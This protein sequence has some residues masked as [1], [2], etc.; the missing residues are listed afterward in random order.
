[1]THFLCSFTSKDPATHGRTDYCRSE[2]GRVGGA[3]A[4]VLGRACLTKGTE[5]E[6]VGRIQHEILHAVGG[7]SRE[8]RRSDSYKMSAYDKVA[9]NIFLSCPKMKKK[10]FVEYQEEEINKNYIEL[11]QLTLN[12]NVRSER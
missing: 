8:I 5:E 4:V 1:M 7:L 9:L 10:V 2:I 3:Q 12:P 11:M 6:I